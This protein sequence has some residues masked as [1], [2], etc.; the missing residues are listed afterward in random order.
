MTSREVILTED[1]KTFCGRLS[2]RKPSFNIQCLRRQGSN[3]DLPIPGTYHPTSPPRRTRTQ[4]THRHTD[5]PPPSSVKRN[6]TLILFL[7]RCSA[8]MSLVTPPVAPQ[9]PPQ[10]PGLT[11]VLVAGASCTLLSSWWRRRAAHLGGEEEE[12]EERGRREEQEEVSRARF[13]V[14]WRSREVCSFN[15]SK[16]MRHSDWMILSTYMVKKKS[17]RSH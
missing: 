1:D 3:D 9:Q 10:R 2:G 17:H 6:P 15:L 7:S 16:Q 14:S 4:V 5:N 8:V 13:T 12:E 11:H